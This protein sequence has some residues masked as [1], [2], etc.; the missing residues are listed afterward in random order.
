ML[1]SYLKPMKRFLLSFA[2]ILFFTSF[3]H[4][5]QTTSWIRINQLGY[6]PN[7]IK[8]AVWC[9]KEQPAVDNWQL[10]EISSGKLVY[11]GKFEKPFGAYGPFMQ[12][13]RLN[14]SS[15]N[16]PGRYYLQAGDTRSPEFEIGDDVYQGAA[17]LFTLYAAAAKW[18][19][20][21]SARY[22]HTRW[23]CFVW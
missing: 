4:L 13:Y 18:L 21:I 16:R 10:V 14:F 2:I 9:S 8:V 3:Q 1:F 11:S 20:S 23:L 5:P 6:K 19:Q 15:F 17:D 12:T 22:C 7:G